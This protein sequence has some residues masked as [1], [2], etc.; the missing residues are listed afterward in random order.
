MNTGKL[1]IK[2]IISLTS[3]KILSEIYT[4]GVAEIVKKIKKNK[5]KVHKLTIKNNTVAVVTDGSAVLGLGNV[6]AF[7]AI[8]VMEGKCAIFKE[9]GKLN[10]F[11]IAIDSQKME[12]IIS[13]IRNIAPVFAAINIEDIA[14]PKCFEIEE[15]LS[16]L[17]IPVVHDDQHA[18]AIIVLAGLINACKIANKNIKKIKIVINGCGAAGTAIIK[19]LYYFGC[20][21]ITAVDSQG[22]VG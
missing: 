3:K 9:F 6:G 22:V 18:T 14:A 16:D 5:N 7:A 15:K 17:G 2:S 21:N 1:E 11:P 8:P 4:P 19:L 10:A 20:K 13:T 12:D